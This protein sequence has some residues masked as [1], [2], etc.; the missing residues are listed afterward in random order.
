MR[1]KEYYRRRQKVDSEHTGLV[2]DY[3]CPV[4][5]S[6]K[7]LASIRFVRI[8]VYVYAYHYRNFGQRKNALC[9]NLSARLSDW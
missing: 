7:F 6:G 5:D 2:L 8:C 3:L 4:D 1:K 9:A